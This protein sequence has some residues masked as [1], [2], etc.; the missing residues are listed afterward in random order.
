MESSGEKTVVDRY[1]LLFQDNSEGFAV[2]IKSL[3]RLADA[4]RDDNIGI[5]LI[6]IPDIH[7]LGNYPFAHIHDLMAKK[8][9][10]MGYIFIDMYPALGDLKPKEI[11]AM[12]GDPH[13][14][15]L[16]HRIMAER[17]IPYFE[18]R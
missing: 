3:E 4:A 5:Y 8:V 18:K 2:A 6:M 9:S 7:N 15:A 12:P 17:M 10:D 16:G 13:P 14:N 11:W 1:N